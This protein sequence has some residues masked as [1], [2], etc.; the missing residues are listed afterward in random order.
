MQF[1]LNEGK[2]H[3]IQD[4]ICASMIES[5]RHT[6]HNPGA[7]PKA[8]KFPNAMYYIPNWIFVIAIQLCVPVILIGAMHTL[9]ITLSDWSAFSAVVNVGLMFWLLSDSSTLR[10]ASGS[11]D[12]KRRTVDEIV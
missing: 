1:Y 11:I 9:S 7:E 4:S 10:P 6:H 5:I 12:K 8:I 3:A 2:G